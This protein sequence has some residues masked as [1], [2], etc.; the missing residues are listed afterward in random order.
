M[1][2]KRVGKPRSKTSGN[3]DAAVHPVPEHPA[4]E[5]Q[6]QGFVKPAFEGDVELINAR[7]DLE[8][9]RTVDFRIAGDGFERMHPFKRFQKKRNGRLGT[10]FAAAIADSNGEVRVNSEVML[11]GWSES[12]TGGQQFSLWLDDEAAVHPFAGCRHRKR[13]EPGE[14]FKVSL[15][16]LQDDASQTPQEA[17][18]RTRK[19]SNDAHLLV[20]GSMFVQYLRETKPNMA[21]WTP[22][23]AKQYVK[24]R[25]GIESL[26][27]LDRIPLKVRE[28]QEQIV[29]PFERWRGGH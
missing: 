15:I 3:G 9:G 4:R 16:E 18:V 6:A 7:W 8:S 21:Q 17:T 19:P 10:I 28:Y 24:S 20:T 13:E 22:E 26:S 12:A 29:R 5:E 23:L 1:A 27:L 14:M 2:T 11:K 25:L